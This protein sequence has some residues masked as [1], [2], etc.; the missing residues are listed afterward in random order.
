MKKKLKQLNIPLLFWSRHDFFQE[1][2]NN[3]N[4][5]K[6]S[7]ALK[8]SEED[9][10]LVKVEIFFAQLKYYEKSNTKIVFTINGICRIP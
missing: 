9:H 7:F 6:V 3:L 1:D 8:E 10:L 5:P 2:V 4:D